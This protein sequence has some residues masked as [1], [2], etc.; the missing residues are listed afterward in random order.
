V[1]YRGSDHKQRTKNFAT[2]ADATRYANLVEADLTRGEWSDPA[3]AKTTFGEWVAK[4]DAGRLNRRTTTRARDETCLRLHVVPTFRSRHIGSIQPADI[5][6]W[7]QELIDKGLAPAT[8]RKCYQLIAGALDAA[9]ND[10]L[11]PRSPA[12][13]VG[14]PKTER[15]AIHFLTADQINTLADAIDQRYRVLVLAAGYSGLRAGELAALKVDR[16]DL[17]RRRLR[18]VDTLV[19][20]G[21]HLETH[22]PKTNASQRSVRLSEALC[23]DLALHLATYPTEAYVFQAPEGGPLRWT[24][25]RR[26][27]WKPAVEQLGIPARFHDLRHSHAA[28]LIAAGEHPKLIASR[29]GHTSVRTVL[30]VYGHLLDGLDD[31]AADRLDEVYRASRVDKMW[32]PG[33]AEVVTL[34]VGSPNS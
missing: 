33:H 3:L 7:V 31:A 20:I 25:F 4:W 23:D 32:T 29:L 5:R 28:L 17:L 27:Y 2:K 11:I 18:V 16:L 14:L 9:V 24:N 34:E 6:E 10:G 26:R 30:D 21:G 15:P 1:R 19:D 13:D 12:R 8:V 22:P